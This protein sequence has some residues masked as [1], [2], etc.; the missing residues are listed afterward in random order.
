MPNLSVSDAARRIS[1]EEGAIVAPPVITTLF[2]RRRLDDT[3]CPV[4]SGRRLIPENYLP[5]IVRALREHGVLPLDDP[6][7][8]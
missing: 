5:E 3:V 8:E 2:Y 7:S 1:D 6:T 4:V